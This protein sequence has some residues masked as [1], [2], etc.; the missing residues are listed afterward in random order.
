MC[1]KNHEKILRTAN[2][3]MSSPKSFLVLWPSRNVCGEAG[4]GSQGII[5]LATKTTKLL[6]SLEPIV[7]LESFV[8]GLTSTIL[9]VTKISRPGALG[10]THSLTHSPHMNAGHIPAYSAGQISQI[11]IVVGWIPGFLVWSVENPSK[12]TVWISGCKVTLL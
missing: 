5:G 8:V 10:V 6:S 2:R 1:C 3:R 4:H 11:R 7:G 9:L 12:P